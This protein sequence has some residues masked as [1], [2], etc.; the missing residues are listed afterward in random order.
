MRARSKGGEPSESRSTPD[1]RGRARPRGVG[2]ATRGR[3]NSTPPEQVGERGGRGA[4]SGRGAPRGRGG[5]RGRGRDKRGR[6][7][8]GEGRSDGERGGGVAVK[9]EESAM[10]GKA[11]VAETIG[12]HNTNH[13]HATKRGKMWQ[14]PAGV[15]R[16]QRALRLSCACDDGG[17]HVLHTQCA[18]NLVGRSPVLVPLCFPVQ[19]CRA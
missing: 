6:G 14:L 16:W 4:P 1:G 12:D 8:G 18:L 19:G 15:T 2:T 13:R 10:K 5:P 17:N 3:R 9:R 7:Y 11:G